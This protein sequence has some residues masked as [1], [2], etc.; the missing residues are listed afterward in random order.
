ML[1][2][3]DWHQWEAGG[4]RTRCGSIARGLSSLPELHRL[5]VVSTPH[6]LAMNATR[7]IRN[8][9]TASTDPRTTLRPFDVREV[10]T[11]VSALEQTRL[12]PPGV[13]RR[14]GGGTANRATNRAIARA[15]AALGMRDWIL[16]VADPLM[17]SHIGETGEALSVFDAI[18]DWTAHPQMRAVRPLAEAGYEVVRERADVVFTVSRALQERLGEGR[19]GVHWIPNGVDA[20]RFDQPTAV[21]DDLANHDGP[22]LGY[23]GVIQERLDVTLVSAVARAL[24][25]CLVVLVGPVC[26]P[27]H[28]E[29]LAALPNVRLIGERCAAE[30]PAYVNAFDVCLMPHVDDALTRSMDPLKIYEY[31]AAGKP[32]VASGLSEMDLPADLVARCDSHEQFVA[33]VRALVDATAITSEDP[34]LLPRKEFARSRSWVSRLDQM[35]GVI[36]VRAAEQGVVLT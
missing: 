21:P 10:S 17:A 36:R 3:N 22:V 8:Q 19:D 11:K 14:A 13:T 12:L 34:Y 26:A 29:P 4:F 35:L 2:F 32:V 9:F 7:A 18:D 25:H 33:T 24:P 30:V 31:L 23:V 6:S 20:S 27:R 28:V 15:C 5:V 1:G 16:W